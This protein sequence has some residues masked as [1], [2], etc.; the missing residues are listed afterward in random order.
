[1]EQNTSFNA[2]LRTY[3]RRS[4]TRHSGFHTCD[5]TTGGEC[6]IKRTEQCILEKPNTFFHF[7][8]QN[9]NIPELFEIN[10]GIIAFGGYVKSS[11]NAKVLIQIIYSENGKETLCDNGNSMISKEIKIL[12]NEWTG[13]GHHGFVDCIGSCFIDKMS[14]N[15]VVDIIQMP[16]ISTQP[17]MQF[18]GFDMGAVTKQDYCDESLYK[19][20]NQNTA[21][22]IPALY[23]LSSDLSIKTYLLPSK[24]CFFGGEYMVLKSCNRCGRY[25][26]INVMDELRT[27]AFSLH[28]KK[29]AP[30]NHS[31]F[32]AYSIQNSNEI[33][34]SQLPFQLDENRKVTTYCGHQLECRACKKFFVNAPLNWVRTHQQHVEDSLRRR[35][36]EVLLTELLQKKTVH[37][38]F[39]HR[40]HQEFSQYIWEK[41][42]KKCF[43]CGKDVLCE[44]KKPHERMHLDHTMP[45]AFLYPLDETAT[46]LCNTCNSSKS[47]HF[48]VDFYTEDELIRLSAITGLSLDVLHSRTINTDNLYLLVENVVWFFDVFL[49]KSEYQ[50]VND[51]ILVANKI[52]D[53]L[54]RVIAGKYDLIEEYKKR[55]GG[56]LPKSVSL[57]FVQ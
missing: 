33:D 31:T 15:M 38:E 45:L 50:K 57:D 36:I 2:N 26:P 22:Y 17:I 24:L 8:K 25:L 13:I 47:D 28:C 30:C 52:N 29:R 43:K 20:F 35:A 53:S 44:T 19:Y 3:Q 18:I 14:V 1:M 10:K 12:A 39:R 42:D 16:P 51:N 49:A 21:M 7:E 40:T 6:L 27:I 54:R 56:R 55:T 34:L 41:F 46:C 11:V 32:K 4:V 37:H 5:E 23:Y 48:P 9:I